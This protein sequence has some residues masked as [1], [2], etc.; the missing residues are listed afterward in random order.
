[1]SEKR[2]EW[3]A[4]MPDGP[5]AMVLNLP[6]IAFLPNGLD[7]PDTDLARDLAIGMKITGEAPATNTLRPRARVPRS[8]LASWEQRIPE[9]NKEAVDMVMK[10]QCSEEAN[11]CRDLS[12]R[13][14][15]RGGVWISQPKPMTQ[16]ELATVPL[17]PRF[18]NPERHGM[19]TTQKIRLIGD[20][21]M[22]GANGLI[23]SA[24]T[25]SPPKG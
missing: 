19:A 4:L 9:A 1:M 21:E 14:A 3:A 5:P 2:K 6:L 22:S 11:A 25:S 7:F 24:D 23:S 16:T 18:A 8:D 15:E 12:L 10:S 20:F 13:Q 17:T